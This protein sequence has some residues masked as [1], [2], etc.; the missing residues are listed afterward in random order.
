M[1]LD[2]AKAV[3][4]NPQ[5]EI[6]SAGTKWLTV[7]LIAFAAGMIAEGLGIELGDSVALAG[8]VV[9]FLG[10]SAVVLSGSQI[11]ES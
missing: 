1:G 5:Y 10:G 2:P 11:S 9:E 3:P 8:S 4:G 7:G 6:Y